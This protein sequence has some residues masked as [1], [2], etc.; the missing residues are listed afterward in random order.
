MKINFPFRNIGVSLLVALGVVFVAGCGPQETALDKEEKQREKKQERE[1]NKVREEFQPVVGTY[2][3]RATTVN[4]KLLPAKLL[5]WTS[6]KVIPNPGRGDSTEVIVLMGVLH[7]LF[8]T[9]PNWFPVATYNTG[10]FP[11]GENGLHMIGAT[12][13][14]QQA[15]LDVKFIDRKLTGWALQPTGLVGLELRQISKKVRQD[16]RRQD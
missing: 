10:S 12:Q 15:E 16:F 7:V 5:I 14:G 11:I 9:D 4:G 3:G 2:E 8:P 6:T 13:N 1:R